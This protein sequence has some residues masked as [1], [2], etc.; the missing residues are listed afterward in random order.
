MADTNKVGVSHII[1]KHRHKVDTVRMHF[2]I[3]LLPTIANCIAADFQVV[4]YLKQAR[5]FPGVQKNFPNPRGK[6]P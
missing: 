2:P 4:R 6:K 3:P 5:A 1:I